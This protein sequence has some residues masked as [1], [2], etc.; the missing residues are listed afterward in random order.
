MLEIKYIKEYNSKN[1]KIG[2]NL[3]DGGGG[4]KGYKVSQETKDKISKTLTGRKSLTAKKVNQYTLNGLF[5][6][7][8][9]SATEAAKELNLTQSNISRVCNKIRN[10]TGGFIFKWEEEVDKFL[11]NE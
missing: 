6:R 9:N 4:M 10:K 1:N 11:K 5:I 8:F 2:Y 3:T 7:S